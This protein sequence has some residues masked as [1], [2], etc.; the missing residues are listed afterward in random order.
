MLQPC[1][2]LSTPVRRSASANCFKQ[3][4]VPLPL[5]LLGEY[6]NL[7]EIWTDSLRPAWATRLMQQLQ[8]GA[9]G[10]PKSPSLWCGTE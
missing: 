9:E 10:T 5:P 6:G 4:F 8:P 3:D 7:T 1:S 2:S